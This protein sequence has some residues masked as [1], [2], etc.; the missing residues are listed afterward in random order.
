LKRPQIVHTNIEFR[1]EE[2]ARSLVGRRLDSLTAIE[3]KAFHL[4]RV[5]DII[6]AD[7]GSEGVD[8]GVVVEL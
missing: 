2:L 7:F 4:C 8:P 6:I 5:M 1:V 3:M